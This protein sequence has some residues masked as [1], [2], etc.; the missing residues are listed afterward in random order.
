MTELSHLRDQADTIVGWKRNADGKPAP[1]FQA[2]RRVVDRTITRTTTADAIVR[3]AIV[4]LDDARH[5]G[6]RILEAGAPH[7]LGHLRDAAEAGD[8]GAVFNAQDA[9]LDEAQAVAEE[10]EARGRRRSMSALDSELYSLLAPLLVLPNVVE[11]IQAE[12]S[13]VNLLPKMSLNTPL[14][15]A[16]Y[17]R[18]VDHMPAPERSWSWTQASKAQGSVSLSTVP[19]KLAPS[20]TGFTLTARDREVFEATRGNQ[21]A[22]S[23]G[24][25]ERLVEVHMR[26][27]RDDIAKIVAY[28]EPA[29]G[30]PG[31]LT[32]GLVTAAN[33]NYDTG[34]SLT[35]YHT[36]AEIFAAQ[37]AQVGHIDQLR[38]DTLLLDAQTFST[39]SMQLLSSTGDDRTPVL[40][41]LLDNPQISRVY[42][43]REFLPI[44]AEITEGTPKYGVTEATRLGGGLFNGGTYHRCLMVTR[45]DE[46][47][48]LWIEGLPLG[49]EAL[50]PRDGADRAQVRSST[51]G[52][53]QF[54]N[55]SRIAYI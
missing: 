17:L 18:V 36:L 16:T 1:V 55:V 2:P 48:H 33:V 51:G 42:S 30:I 24:L 41:A 28:G 6:R 5:P 15:D 21:G 39:W 46:K 37:A 50:D 52:Y 54:Q 27:V 29:Y 13:L 11:R 7:L 22:P 4:P 40:Q 14:E 8:E 44:A 9:F 43:V 10:I 23:W 38:A 26:A 34:V 45:L 53:Q 49:V 35:D 3:R 20:S 25:Y 12:P 19:I 47:I 31:V 32:P